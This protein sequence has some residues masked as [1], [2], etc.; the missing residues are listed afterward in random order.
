M[1][2]LVRTFAVTIPAGTLVTAAQVTDLAMPS[3][4]VRSVR[5]R[6]PPGP[7][8][9]VGFALTSN[10]QWVIP[11][12]PS[13]YLVMDNEVVEWP[14]VGQLETGAWQLRGYNTGVY[15]HTIY[16]TF[17]LDPLAARGALGTVTQPLSL[18]A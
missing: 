15:D 7:A 8:G 6:V 10:R 18:E 16:L 13:T 11:E 9:L 5:I 17:L 4:I 12:V 14:L 3:R 2:S 1:A